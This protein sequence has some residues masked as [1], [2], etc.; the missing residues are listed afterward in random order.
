MS[1]G[2]ATQA[3]LAEAEL[4]PACRLDARASSRTPDPI[5]RFLGISYSG[6][7]SSMGW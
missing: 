1:P 4:A 3:R 2:D 7:S 6:I 5:Y